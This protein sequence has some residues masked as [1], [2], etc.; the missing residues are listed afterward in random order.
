MD[1]HWLPT[2]VQKRTGSKWAEWL[3]FRSTRRVADDFHILY[4]KI[5]FLV[6]PLNG[7]TVASSG[8]LIKNSTYNLMHN[9]TGYNIHID[10]LYLFCIETY[11]TCIKVLCNTLNCLA[12]NILVCLKQYKIIKHEKKYIYNA[13]SSSG[14]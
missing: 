10:L 5:S 6:I 14:L 11:K 4:I 9:N 1:S 7:N 12:K 2:P 3:S 13:F 8:V